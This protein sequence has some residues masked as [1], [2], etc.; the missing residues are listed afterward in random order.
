MNPGHTHRTQC[1]DAKNQVI[2]AKQNRNFQANSRQQYIANRHV[3][4][5]TRLQRIYSPA[6]NPHI[7]ALHPTNTIFAMY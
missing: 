2:L 1:G 6:E 3:H 4:S 7:V 5:P